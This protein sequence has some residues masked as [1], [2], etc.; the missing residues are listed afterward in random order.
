MEKTMVS[1]ILLCL[2]GAAAAGVPG[3][4][5]S[6]RFNRSNYAATD[7]SG[8]FGSPRG[9]VFATFGGMIIGMAA[10]SLL[11]HL[12]IVP[13]DAVGPARIV[14]M[15]VGAVAGAVGMILG[16][17]SRKSNDNTNSNDKKSS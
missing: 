1:T 7:K 14:A 15:L 11:S 8:D 6:F 3:Y 2:V 17:K 10:I 13:P 4:L 5:I 12:P 16:Q 9:G